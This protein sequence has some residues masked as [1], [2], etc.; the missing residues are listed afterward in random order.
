MRYSLSIK[1]KEIVIKV[2]FVDF[3]VLTVHLHF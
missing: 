1:L 3:V 2:D